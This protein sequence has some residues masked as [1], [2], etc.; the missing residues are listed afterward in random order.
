MKVTLTKRQAEL[1]VISMDAF[2]NSEMYPEAKIIAKKLRR[3]MRE[4]RDRKGAR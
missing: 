4:S 2:D 3:A 1:V